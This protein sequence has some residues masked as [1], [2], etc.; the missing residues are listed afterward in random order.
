M[1]NIRPSRPDSGLGVQIKL[2]QLFLCRSADVRE[3]LGIIILPVPAALGS[4]QIAA[5]RAI[6]VI[7]GRVSS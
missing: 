6:A 3:R 5:S 1:A 2:L 4:D 7:V